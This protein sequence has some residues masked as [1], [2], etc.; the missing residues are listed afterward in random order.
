[1]M[2]QLK[3]LWFSCF[4][5]M[6]W[7]ESV[8]GRSLHIACIRSLLYFIFDAQTRTRGLYMELGLPDFLGRGCMCGWEMN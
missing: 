4:L 6:V 3:R 1:M 2:D 8:A 5:V 7:D